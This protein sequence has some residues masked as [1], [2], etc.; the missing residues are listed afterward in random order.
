M[1]F[2]PADCPIK[3][4][5]SRLLSVIG[6]PKGEGWYVYAIVH[7]ENP[8]KLRYI[9]CTSSPGTRLSQH[10]TSRVGWAISDAR[11]DVDMMILA[12][13]FRSERKALRLE[14]FLIH[15]FSDVQMCDLNIFGNAANQAEMQKRSR[16]S[17]MRNRE[18]V[19]V[20]VRVW[21]RAKRS[22]ALNGAA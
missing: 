6:S 8:T 21:H 19:E 3:V 2:N 11:K 16:E 5:P 1:D 9:G 13:P 7:R 18:D 12:G 17:R 20:F 4:G 10:K 22:S 15:R 14:R